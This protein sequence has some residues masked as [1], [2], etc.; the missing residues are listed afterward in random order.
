MYIEIL[1]QS[2][3]PGPVG[4]TG[5]LYIG[6]AGLARGYFNRPEL[7]AEKFIGI[8]DLKNLKG[9]ARF[10]K[11]GDLARYL[12]DANIEFLGRVDSQIK[13]RGFRIELG[14]IE[15]VLTQH[16]DIQ[17]AVVMVREDV[18]DDKRLVSY[19][20]PK[21]SRMPTVAG[22]PRYI[23]PNNLA[24]AHLNQNE[25]DFLYKEIFEIKAYLKHGITIQ[26]GDCIFDVGTNIGLFS[27]FAHLSANPIKIYGFEPNPFV[28]EKLEHNT[29]LYQVDAKLFNCGLSG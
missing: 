8:P 20:V 6:G 29:A 2:L 28:F 15:S 3:Q 22:K 9:I 11:T 7:T 1:D 5:E 13:L 18:A 10:Y 24:I 25:T 27:L 4:E 26:D 12:P 23:L 14:E 21:P 19:V 16:P 17:Q